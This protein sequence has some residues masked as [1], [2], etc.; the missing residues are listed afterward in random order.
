MIEA[1]RSGPTLSA[2]GA[3]RLKF[4]AGEE[5]TVVATAGLAPTPL[6]SR[7]LT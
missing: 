4:A 7:N 6:V 5:P 2:A 1:K 3:D